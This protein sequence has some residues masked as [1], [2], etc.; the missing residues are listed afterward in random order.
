MILVAGTAWVLR[1]RLVV[2]N[3]FQVVMVL[4]DLAASPIA[5][6]LR[7]RGALVDAFVDRFELA[8]VVAR[9]AVLHTL[10]NEFAAVPYL[11]CRQSL[12]LY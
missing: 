10:W 4:V 3:G 2:R 1:R 6:R 12:A 9:L 5:I 8:M 7:V 11:L